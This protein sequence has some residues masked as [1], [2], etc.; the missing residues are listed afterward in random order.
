MGETCQALAH[1]EDAALWFRKAADLT[2]GDAGLHVALGRCLLRL[3]DVDAARHAFQ[4]ALDLQPDLAEAH[5]GIGLCLQSTGRFQEAVA[6]HERALALRPDLHDAHINLAMIQSAKVDQGEIARLEVLL[7]DPDLPA[8]ARISLNFAVAK[9]HQST[10]DPDA[11]FAHFRAGN[12]LKARTLGFDP[13]RHTDFV[14]RCI[15]TF[16]RDFFAARRGWGAASETPVFILGMPR[17]GT[18]LVEQILSAHPD[19]HGAG[20]LDDFRLLVR[21]LP[22]RPGTTAGFPDCAR[23]LD[24]TACAALARSHLDSLARRFPPAARV[25]DKMTGNYLRLGLIAMLL[26]QATVIHCRR[27]PLD[28]CLSCYFQNFA[29]G[30][31]FTYDLGHLGVVYRQYARLMAHWREVLPLRVLDVQYESLVA[32]PETVSREIVDFCNLP[33]DARC[34]AFHQHERQVQ[35]ASFWQVRQPIYASSV[36]RW[37]AYAHHLGP[38]REALGMVGDGTA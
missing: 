6:A 10:G 24:Q 25:T 14:D 29:N 16:D 20:E 35:T 38:L 5:F 23:A 21:D 26:P 22:A 34:L 4:A 32:A 28:T 36:S 12:A 3:G 2:P 19:V 7:A 31:S 11:A 17:S 18:T 15:A 37:Q 27:D 30:L 33:W 1:H 8:D 13:A 9:L